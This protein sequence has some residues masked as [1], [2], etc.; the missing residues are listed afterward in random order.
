MSAY[1]QFKIVEGA[2]FAL[3]GIAVVNVFLFLLWLATV[4][5]RAIVKP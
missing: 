1:R 4:I 2:V 5:A 3:F